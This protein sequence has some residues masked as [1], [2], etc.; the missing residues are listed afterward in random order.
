M[1]TII[2]ETEWLRNDYRSAITIAAITYRT[3]EHAYQAAKTSDVATKHLIA[4]TDSVRE[5]RKIGRSIEQAE[6]FNRERVMETLQR[7]KFS[8]PEL[9][10][11]LISTGTSD[12]IMEGYD[13]FWGTGECGTG[14]NMMGD[15]L[16]KIR[17]EQS[18]LNGVDLED[19]DIE[20]GCDGD[21]CNCQ[22]SKEEDSVPT[23]KDALINNPDDDLATA[24]QN[25]F[26]GAKAIVSLLDANDYN[27]NYISKK[28]G[29]PLDQ[30]EAAIKKVQAFQSTITALENLLEASDEEDD[31]DD[32][33][34]DEEEFDD[35]DDDDDEDRMID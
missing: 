21:C 8:T 19:L 31:D 6:N 16:E 29:A 23:L 11:K 3:L 2:G 20:D 14:D 18:I 34:E 35:D 30:V 17:K 5:A 32:D 26:D 25:L 22:C 1:Q 10:D 7:V 24:C 4:Q 27:A 28:T 12:I 15:I 13:E 33:E 9:S